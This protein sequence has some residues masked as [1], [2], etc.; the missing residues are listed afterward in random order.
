MYLREGLGVD[1]CPLQTSSTN[2]QITAC[3][4]IKWIAEENHLWADEVLQLLWEE[5]LRYFQHNTPN[6]SKQS[7]VKDSSHCFEM[8]VE[9]NSL[10]FGHQTYKAWGL[11]SFIT[12]AYNF[13]ETLAITGQP[14]GP[15]K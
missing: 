14:K 5:P 3:C 12:E 7:D 15:M 10:D 8:T 6:R 1:S 2:V 4:K 11:S 13:K 9:F